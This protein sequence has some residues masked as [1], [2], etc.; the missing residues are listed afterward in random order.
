MRVTRI[1]AHLAAGA[2][3]LGDAR[4]PP[5][6]AQVRLAVQLSLW[7]DPITQ[8]VKVSFNLNDGVSA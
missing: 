3:P 4:F 5:L 8:T 6:P 2:Q 7:V 1:A